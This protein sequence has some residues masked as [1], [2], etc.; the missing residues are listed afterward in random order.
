[1]CSGQSQCCKKCSV[2]VS[3]SMQTC[4]C[5]CWLSA[6]RIQQL[7]YSWELYPLCFP[8]LLEE[9]VLFTTVAESLNDGICML[10][11]LFALFLLLRLL[12][13]DYRGKLQ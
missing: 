5:F 10:K 11:L 1:M 3:C 2:Q 13:F 12:M 7:S 6:R 8:Q 4:K 9:G